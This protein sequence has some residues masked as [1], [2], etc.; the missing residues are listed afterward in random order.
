[1]ALR[2]S[3]RAPRSAGPPGL[4]AL[5][6]FCS[7]NDPPRGPSSSLVAPA[8]PAR[9]PLRGAPRPTGPSPFLLLYRSPE[10]ALITP[11]RSGPACAPPAPRGPQACGPFSLSAPLTIPR[12]GPSCRAGS[13]VAIRDPSMGEIVG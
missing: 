9:P 3:L 6:P 10:G 12:G 1:M 8:Q 13:L 2:P 5:L 11:G 7:F 4:R